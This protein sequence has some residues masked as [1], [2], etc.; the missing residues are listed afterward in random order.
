MRRHFAMHKT[1][2]HGTPVVQKT[3]LTKTPGRLITSVVIALAVAT[4]LTTISLAKLRLD[5]SAQEEAD[6]RPRTGIDVRPNFESPS[7]DSYQVL[8][9]FTGNDGH[10]FNGDTDG[11]NPAALLLQG[12][13]G[14]LY[15]TTL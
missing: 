8:H 10:G 13:D 15:G 2:A 7:A 9:S 5:A 3:F 12:P 11:A 4:A 14:N 6:S 1:I